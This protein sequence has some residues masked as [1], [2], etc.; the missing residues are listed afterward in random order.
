MKEEI[1]HVHTT[2]A[3][4]S[5]GVHVIKILDIVQVKCTVQK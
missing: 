4:V 1:L 2:I 3:T 5:T